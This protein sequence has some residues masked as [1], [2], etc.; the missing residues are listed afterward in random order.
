MYG[1]D[2]FRLLLSCLLVRRCQL[3][4]TLAVGPFAIACDS[5]VEVGIMQS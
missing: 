4:V 2:H 3:L 1:R 5:L